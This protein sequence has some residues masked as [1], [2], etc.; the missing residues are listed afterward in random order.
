MRDILVIGLIIAVVVIL[1]R[2]IMG[3]PM[4]KRVMESFSGSMLNSQTE[5]P[6][7]SQLYMH[8]GV[9]YCCSGKINEDANSATESC[10][11]HHTSDLTF[12]TLG[13]SRSDVPNCMNTK[14][15]QYN[16]IGAKVCP[17][18]APT[19]VQNASGVGRCCTGPANSDRTACMSDTGSCEVAPAGT[20]I[21]KSPLP[22]CQFQ[23]LVQTDGKCPSSTT[24]AMVPGNI[25]NGVLTGFN[26]SYCIGNRTSCLT[27]PVTDALKASKYEDYVPNVES[28]V[29]LPKAQFLPWIRS[30]I[31][32]QLNVC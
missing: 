14:E 21:L 11:A 1:I 13:P 27:K 20:N 29:G 26:Y 17:P 25:Q 7:G 18:S 23:K 10:K 15:K 19:Y 5:C 3:T 30:A 32:E 24:V 9:V 2:V 16:D 22:S 8:D 31:D 12:C 28:L 6:V 4:I